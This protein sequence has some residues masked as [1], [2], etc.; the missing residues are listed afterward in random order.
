M[1]P[2]VKAG[3]NYSNYCALDVAVVLTEKFCGR[4]LNSS[5]LKLIFLGFLKTLGLLTS[6][7]SVEPGMSCSYVY[8]RFYIVTLAETGRFLSFTMLTACHTQVFIFETGTSHSLMTK[9]KKCIARRWS[10]A[11][12]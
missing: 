5:E 1:L 10:C 9:G 12:N 6:G 2:N 8:Y 7:M 3:G 11:P 4:Q